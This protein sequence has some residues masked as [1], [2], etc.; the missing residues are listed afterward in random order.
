MR[1]M[2]VRPTARLIVVD[3][4]DRVLLIQY[5]NEVPLD[6]AEPTLTIYWATPGGGVEPGETFEQAAQREL[7]EETGIREIV[8]PWIW[9]RTRQLSFVDE[10]LLFDER[11]FLVR[12]ETTDVALDNL[13]ADE[14]LVYRAHHWWT[15]QDMRSADTAILPHGLADLLAPIVAGSLP[16]QPLVIG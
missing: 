12:V 16:A 15:L 14:R 3:K 13:L 7:W 5:E 4:D 1:N 9:S 11:Y 6:P 2:R 10:D 8:G